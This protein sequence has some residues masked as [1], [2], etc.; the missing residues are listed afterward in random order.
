MKPMAVLVPTRVEVAAKGGGYKW[1]DGYKIISPESKE[2][3]PYMR[4]AAA[5]RYCKIAGWS[6]QVA[7]FY[8]G[9]NGWG[10][11]ASEQLVKDF[12]DFTGFFTKEVK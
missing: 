7:R 3:Q 8:D 4:K 5:K 6:W 11:R 2:M 10:A 9:I 1:V 12:T